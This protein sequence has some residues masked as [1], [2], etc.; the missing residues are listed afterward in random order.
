MRCDIQYIVYARFHIR[1]IY[2]HSICMK[3]QHQWMNKKDVAHIH[4]ET[5][6]HH[7]KEGYPIICNNMD[8]L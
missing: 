4:S 8:R 2:I 6:F 5:A 1:N 3:G 7:Q